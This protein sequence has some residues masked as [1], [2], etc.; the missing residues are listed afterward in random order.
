MHGDGLLVGAGRELVGGLVGTVFTDSGLRAT[1]YRM[2]RITVDMV[3]AENAPPSQ[4]TATTLRAPQDLG[5]IVSAAGC[6]GPGSR[7]LRQCSGKECRSW[8]M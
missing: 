8:P 6:G 1:V 2:E 3:P 4:A 5:Q 7:R